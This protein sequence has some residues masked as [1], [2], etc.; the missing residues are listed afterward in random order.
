MQGGAATCPTWLAPF[1]FQLILCHLLTD[2]PD[3]RKDDD[4]PVHHE[5]PIGYPRTRGAQS[6]MS[7]GSESAVSAQVSKLKQDVESERASRAKLREEVEIERE[8]VK[9]AITELKRKTDR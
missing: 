5:L 6:K 4:H 2:M 3:E 1:K 7:T 9:K 8:R